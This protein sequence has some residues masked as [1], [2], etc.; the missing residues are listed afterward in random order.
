MKL[1]KESAADLVIC[2][3][4]LITGILLLLDPIRFTSTVI[5][6]PASC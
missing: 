3:V 2:L 1:W 6:G 4:E 5:I